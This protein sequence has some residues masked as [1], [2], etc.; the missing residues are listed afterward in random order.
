[1]II[2]NKGY[3]NKRSINSE[4]RVEFELSILVI[5]MVKKAIKRQKSV[6]TRKNGKITLKSRKQKTQG[7]KYDFHYICNY[8]M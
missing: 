7:Q 8:I 5:Q 4:V 2:T 3:N 6:N 1:M